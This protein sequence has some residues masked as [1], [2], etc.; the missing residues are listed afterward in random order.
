ML[1]RWRHNLLVA[2]AN[3]ISRHPRTVLALA[4]L[5]AAASIAVTVAR[6]EFHSN[7]NDLIS[8]ELA[9]NQRFIDWQDRF[10][11]SR[12]LVVV[13]DRQSF[14]QPD[15]AERAVDAIAQELT[16]DPLLQQV[17][18]RFPTR[19]I[20]P[21]CLRLAHLEEFTARLEQMRQARPLLENNSLGGLL[22]EVMRQM[23]EQSTTTHAEM[24]PLTVARQIDELTTLIT[25]VGQDLASPDAAATHLAAV[26]EQAQGDAGQTWQYLAS[27]NNRLLFVRITA[28]TQ[29]GMLNALEP[30]IARIRAVIAQVSTQFPGAEMGLTGIEV[31]EA[32]ETTA[33]TVDS[34]VASL[35]AVVLISLLLIVAFHSVR[36]PLLAM[37]ALLVG[38]AWSFGFLTLAI[39]HLQVLSV[40]FTVILLGLGIAYG[41]HLASSLELVRHDHDDT[42]EGFAAALAQAFHTTGPGIVTGAVT[43]AGAFLTTVFT[44]FT[45]MA[46][47]GLIAAVGVMLCLL[48]M[49]SVFPA[50]LRIYKSGHRHIVPMDARKVHLFEEQW[51]RPF[52]R[53]PRLTLGLTALLSLAAAVWVGRSIYFDFDLMKLQPASAPAVQWANRI[54]RDGGQSIYFGV[55]L[56]R[57]TDHARELADQL[58]AQ[59]AISGQLGGVGLLFPE[60]EPHKLELL[61]ATRAELQPA[62]AAAQRETAPAAGPA[63][64]NLVSNLGAMQFGVNAA[65]LTQMPAEIREA[66]SRL[67]AALTQALTAS[68]ALDD[69]ARAA[70][71][72]QLDQTYRAAR[73]QIAQQM[74]LALDG[75]PLQVDDLPAEVMR[76]Y[77]DAA[78]RLVIESYPKLEEGQSPLDARV[79]P[80]YI[81]QLESVDPNATGV[82]VQIYH[83]GALIRDAY[84]QAGAWALLIV[85]VMVLVDF[86]TLH[87]SL[88]SLVPVAIGFLLT[89]AI[90][91]ALDM[92][93]NPANIIVLPLMFGIGVD[94][95]VH[96]LHRYRLQ[97][98]EDPPGLTRGTG[99]G[100]VITTLTTVIGFATMLIASH[101]GIRSLGFVL[102]V[103]VFL[104]MVACLL[105]MPAWLSLRRTR[106]TA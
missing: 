87:D 89:F 47:M 7:R 37:A 101:R 21:R 31:V 60:D 97:P 53:H 73:R 105:V 93:I 99:K 40:V 84:V 8:P 100:I 42:A 6:L 48:A 57:D 95:G 25:A 54:V 103:G 83:S 80:S 26:L 1:E 104:T 81:Q 34:T 61:A 56:A 86:R 76:S 36:S 68:S 46:E 74:T 90:M 15:D 9:W 79:L 52:I 10:P 44:D 72:T 27:P 65:L 13:V 58:R 11:G 71:L 50:L 33:A 98:D 32:D 12:D 20:S 88:L 2:W 49:F 78:G 18:A 35:I 96:M 70:R 77:R 24:E 38:I 14:A 16:G 62:L 94:S 22:G 51:V 23:R 92:P 85:F 106:R 102:S 30:A 59:P 4:L 91:H 39:G 75:A 69:A 43:T 64:V 29:A 66:L 19:E 5:L 28:V 63:T 82:I 45:G 17:V 3:G 41:I 67:S 55:S